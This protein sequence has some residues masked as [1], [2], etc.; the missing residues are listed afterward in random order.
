MSDS[1]DG[2]TDSTGCRIRNVTGTFLGLLLASADVI[3]TVSVNVP[4]GWPV[5][6]NVRTRSDGA[7]PGEPESESQVTLGAS[8][9]DQ[10]RLPLPLLVMCSVSV[11]E[12]DDPTFAESV[13]DAGVTARTGCCSLRITGIRLV[14][15]ASGETMR[16]VSRYV[17]AGRAP[18]RIVSMIAS[19]APP[20]V[21]DRWTHVLS[22]V[23]VQVSDPVPPLEIRTVSTKIVE[24]PALPL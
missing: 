3:T 16:I 1:D 22:F 20:E 21:F 6:F 13:M 14:V 2:V 4:A 8:D 18:T 7:K 5:G 12:V 24:L 23:A 9:A 11:R 15:P 10:F 19:G 17:P